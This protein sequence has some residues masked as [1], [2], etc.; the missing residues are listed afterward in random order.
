MQEKSLEWENGG[1]KFCLPE[2]T[3]RLVDI[4]SKMNICVGH[5]P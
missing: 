3:N 2:N 1:Y 5:V 4:G